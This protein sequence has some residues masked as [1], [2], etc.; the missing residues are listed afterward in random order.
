MKKYLVP[1]MLVVSFVPIVIITLSVCSR[2]SDTSVII[3]GPY[4]QDLRA[5]GI[6]IMW[7]TKNPATGKVVF[8]KSRSLGNEVFETDLTTIHEIMLDELNVET[9]YYYQVIS[10]STK[11]KVYTFK[12]AVERDS[13]FTFAVYGDNKNGPHNHKRIADLIFSKRPGFAIHCGDMVNRGYIYKQWEKFFFTPAREMMREIPLFPLLG[14]HEEHAQLYYDFFSLP[15]NAQW[16]SFNYGNAHFV[17]LDSDTKELE[18]DG[19][20]ISWLIEDLENNTAEWT[21]VSFHHPPFTAGGNYYR[22]SRIY[23]K[24]LLYP[25]LEKYGVDIV[26][27]GHDHNY[28]RTFPIVTRNGKKPV[29]YIVCGN[30]GTPMRYV[31]KRKWTLY[32]ERVFGF[33]LV[34]I[35]G[36]RICLESID[37]DD[38]VIDE[39]NLDKGDPQSTAAYRENS[40]FYEDIID[41]IEAINY[42]SAGDDLLDEENYEEA[43]VEFKK[44]YN[45]DTTCVEALAGIAEC[46][47][48][49]QEFNKAVHYAKQGIQKMYN[50]PDSYEVLIDVYMEKKEWNTAMDWAQKWLQIEPD[51]PDA[52]EVMSEI[53]A[54]QE[55]YNLAIEEMKK[56][57]EIQPAGAGLYFQLGQLYEKVGDNN[58]ALRAY[59]KGLDWF[60]DD[61]KIRL[62]E[63]LEEKI[64]MLKMSL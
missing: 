61:R 30:G 42:Y 19:D 12:T 11:S 8:G 39:L 25:I 41:P 27:N 54:E 59:Q 17:I 29:T 50:Y 22:K 16:Y 55:K 43:I 49:M 5:D 56:A 40:I 44:A 14:N 64:S 60:M 52:N 33:V 36:E 2:V 37:I 63:R 13:P 1:R 26:F 6:T 15:N 62:K 18:K 53:Y 47:Y 20:Q 7:E 45:V 34:N 31:G 46:Y 28:E 32:S 58:S 9:E 3:K 24:N 57:L 23:R 35:D 38:E 51:S 21:F 4:L 10:N 48:E